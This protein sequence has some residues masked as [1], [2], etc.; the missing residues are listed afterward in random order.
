MCDAGHLRKFK[1][2]TLL[3]FQFFIKQQQQKNLYQ[4][5]KK[6]SYNTYQFVYRL[7]MVGS[8]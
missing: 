3:Q 6:H 8:P 7:V 1:I 2:T 4:I 5:V